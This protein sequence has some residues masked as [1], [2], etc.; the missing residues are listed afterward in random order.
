MAGQVELVQRSKQTFQAIKNAGTGSR[1]GGSEGKATVEH[2]DL[3]NAAAGNR[4]VQGL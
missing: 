2:A 4:P 1:T 3:D